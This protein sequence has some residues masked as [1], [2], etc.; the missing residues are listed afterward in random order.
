VRNQMHCMLVGLLVLSCAAYT[1]S[2]GY[3]APS[4]GNILAK[5]TFDGRVGKGQKVKRT[6]SARY[7]YN[8][9]DYIPNPAAGE[10]GPVLQN[11]GGGGEQLA[12]YRSYYNNAATDM[13]DGRQTLEMEVHHSWCLDSYCTR[14]VD[15]VMPASGSFTWE[16]VVRIDAFDGSD[17]CGMLLDNSKGAGR[18][19]NWPGE[20]G[21]SSVITR[22]WMGPVKDGVFPLQFTV[23][24]DEHGRAVTISSDITIGKWY[25]IAAVYDDTV[26]KSR[27]YINDKL[28]AEGD[29]ISCSNRATGFGIGW[30]GP[31]VFRVDHPNRLQKAL[32]DAIAM[33][34]DVRGPGAFLLGLSK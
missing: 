7:P 9:E 16:L 28:S 34:S 18:Y 23:P 32:F 17:H 13:A 1:E 31:E 15:T 11:P 22:L 30:Y 27:L 6:G 24:L 25:H 33:T 10:F 29:V 14:N 19:P 2:L 20:Y 8:G 4:S 26:H 5:Y 21:N 12:Y 3:T